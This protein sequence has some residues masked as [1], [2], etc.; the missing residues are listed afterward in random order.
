MF[1]IHCFI[2]VDFK[3]VKASYIFLPFLLGENGYFGL[4]PKESQDYHV[5]VKFS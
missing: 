2:K 1:P 3:C 5:N 4:L